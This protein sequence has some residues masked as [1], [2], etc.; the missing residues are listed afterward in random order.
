MQLDTAIR[1]SMLLEGGSA[2]VAASASIDAFYD[3]V[4]CR[5]TTSPM[6]PFAV[7]LNEGASLVFDDKT[8]K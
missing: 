4:S 1:K 7:Q 5:N 8:K 3:A 2:T 6:L